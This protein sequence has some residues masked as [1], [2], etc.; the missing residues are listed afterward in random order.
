M[1][2]LKETPLEPSERDGKRFLPF[3]LVV[4]GGDDLCLV[5]DKYYVASFALE[6]S[7]AVNGK[8]EKLPETHRLNEKW[9]ENNRDQSKRDGKPIKP[10]GFGAAFVIASVHTPF[11]RIHQVGED[12]MKKAKNETKK[13]ANSVDWRIMAEEESLTE[14]LLKFE[15]PLFI[16][17][18]P[19]ET[20]KSY[21][22]LLKE[23]KLRGPD[24]EGI[25]HGRLATLLELL[26]VR[27][28]EDGEDRESIDRPSNRSKGR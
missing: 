23:P 10:Y 7:K 6:L 9:L 26:S 19:D 4:A 24:G 27:K 20:E 1:Q 13:K 28:T 16:D 12:L 14:Q 22:D 21:S 3:R 18:K 11:N 15:R 17:R 2:T 5:M 25:D 8:F